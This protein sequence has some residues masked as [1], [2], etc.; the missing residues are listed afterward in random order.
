[1]KR[2]RRRRKRQISASG[3]LRASASLRALGDPR[4]NEL[5]A[6]RACC[7]QASCRRAGGPLPP[8][9][10]AGVRRS[11]MRAPACNAMFAL[12][13][14]CAGFSGSQHRAAHARR[15]TAVMDRAASLLSATRKIANMMGFHA[16]LARSRARAAHLAAHLFMDVGFAQ[17]S[18]AADNA[19]FQF[20]AAAYRAFCCGSIKK[21]KINNMASISAMG[22]AGMARKA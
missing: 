2:R 18:F 22:A 11:F 8:P 3:S 7:G 4:R 20:F 10:C 17:V 13:L 16:P 14:S 15:A 9:P 1:V 19:A 12:P 5:N 6:P 21:I